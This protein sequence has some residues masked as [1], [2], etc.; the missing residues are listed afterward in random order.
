MPKMVCHNFRPKI[1][2]HKTLEQFQMIDFMTEISKIYEKWYNIMIGKR[3]GHEIS[4]M[5]ASLAAYQG[6]EISISHGVKEELMQLEILD[7]DGK[8]RIKDPK[9]V[10]EWLEIAVRLEIHHIINNSKFY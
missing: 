5:I 7:K 9:N 1:S 3:Y 2:Y 10:T 4:H 8:V 6:G